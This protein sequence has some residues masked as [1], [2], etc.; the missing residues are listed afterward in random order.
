MFHV[1]LGNRN[2]GAMFHVEQQAL[3]AMLR[4]SIRIPC[5]TIAPLFV[6]RWIKVA[7]I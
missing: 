4:R 1:K 7:P 6:P 5:E 2:V 3:T